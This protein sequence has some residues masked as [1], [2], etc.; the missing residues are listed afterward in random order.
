MGET[1]K[2]KYNPYSKTLNFFRKNNETKKWNVL[3]D[4]TNLSRFSS[5][6]YAIQN[7][8]KD[9]IEV[10][11]EEY[12][13][14]ISMHQILYCGTKNDFNDFESIFNGL[15][16]K[17]ITLAFDDKNELID[18]KK[19]YKEINEAYTKIKEEFNDYDTASPRFSKLTDS[20]KAIGY[21]I[22]KYLEIVK[23]EINICVIGN[24]SV[25]KSAFINALIGIDLLPSTDD[26]TTA[27]VV[28][29]SNSDKISVQFKYK[30]KAIQIE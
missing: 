23:P 8:A 30:S 15:N 12:A 9:I 5:G 24:Y 27:R 18:S 13:V 26:P 11:D 7:C 19:A 2:I 16:K 29:I 21:K 10:F 28:K 22:E 17:S 3:G 6:R 4:S 14:G 20:Q 25:G 1:L